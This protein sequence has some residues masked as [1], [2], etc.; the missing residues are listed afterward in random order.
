MKRRSVLSLAAGAVLASGAGI[1]PIPLGC[2][3]AN[4]NGGRPQPGLGSRN[5]A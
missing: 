3:A 5:A 4:L 2:G 1:A